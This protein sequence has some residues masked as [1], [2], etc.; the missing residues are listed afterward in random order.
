MSFWLSSLEM[1]VFVVINERDIVIE[2]APITRRFIGQPLKNL[3]KWMSVQGGLRM[4]ELDER[5]D[6]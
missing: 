6:V 4:E 2:T 3:V 5:L 1:T